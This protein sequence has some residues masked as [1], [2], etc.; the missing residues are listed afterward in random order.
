MPRNGILVLGEGEE[1][2]CSIGCAIYIGKWNA[3]SFRIRGLLRLCFGTRYYAVVYFALAIAL[4]TVTRIAWRL[5]TILTFFSR[6]LSNQNID[7]RGMDRILTSFRSATFRAYRRRHM[8]STF[9]SRLGTRLANTIA[10]W[11][12]WLT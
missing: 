2:P 7:Q 6:R 4:R 10:K 11:S 12:K 8:N 1:V 9:S 5:A 3:A